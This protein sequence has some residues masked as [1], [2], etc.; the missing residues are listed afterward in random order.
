MLHTLPA[1]NDVGPL[2]AAAGITAPLCDPRAFPVSDA[3][4]ARVVGWDTR[5]LYEPADDL[6]DLW[7]RAIE[8]VAADLP[9]PQ[10]SRRP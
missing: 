9:R 3:L 2:H 1:F 8:R 5:E 7:E 4:A 10:P 6:I